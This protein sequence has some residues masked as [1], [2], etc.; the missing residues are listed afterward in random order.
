LCVVSRTTEH[1]VAVVAQQT[2]DRTGGVIVVNAPSVPVQTVP[3]VGIVRAADGAAS[4]LV[5]KERLEL[6]ALKPVL[7]VQMAC[8]PVVR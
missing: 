7:H 1:D 8:P 3:P 5:L 6:A 4:V 2:A